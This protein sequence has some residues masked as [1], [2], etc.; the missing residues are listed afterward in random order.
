MSTS[1]TRE[2]ADG[3]L[4]KSTGI[5]DNATSTAI[6]IDASEN[7][8]IG[9]APSVPL[10]V[11]KAGSTSA[12]QE[13]IRLE[14]N[15]TGGT[16]AGSSMNFHHYHAG[17][18][19]AGGAKAASITVVNSGSWAA[20]TPSSYS[21]DLTFGTIHEN[22]FGERLR[23]DSSGNVTVNNGNLVIG[24][25]GKGID[26]SAN[27]DSPVTGASTTSELLDDYEEGYFTPI[28]GTYTGTAPTVS[29][30][31]MQGQYTKVGNLVTCHVQML[32]ITL[33]GTTSGIS[34][35][36]GMPFVSNTSSPNV[37]AT[38][39]LGAVNRITFSRPA[40]Q[41][42]QWIS[43]VGV[44][45]LSNTN[46]GGWGWETNTIYQSNSILRFSI[47]YFTDS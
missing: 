41:G 7:V 22:T 38:G 30:T 4:F 12:V 3:E 5:D 2:K 13:F 11:K 34:V 26:F 39:C 47:S 10:H 29:A 18:G 40:F 25:N 15:A 21:T 33:S 27:T 42:L 23:I 16:G 6:T 44:A 36:K 20:G 24:T 19:P 35:I 46:G 28:I 1:R 32:G 8:G 31:T 43:N 17:S 9:T 14:N 45:F 37:E